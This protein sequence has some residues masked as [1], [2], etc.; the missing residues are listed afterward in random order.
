[1]YIRLDSTAHTRTRTKKTCHATKTRKTVWNWS[2]VTSQHPTQTLDVF[3]SPHT[4]SPSPPP[5]PCLRYRH[6]RAHTKIARAPPGPR[7]PLFVDAPPAAKSPMTYAAK[8]RVHHGITPTHLEQHHCYQHRPL[9]LMDAPPLLFAP[10]FH[11][12]IGFQ[13]IGQAAPQAFTCENDLKLPEPAPPS[14]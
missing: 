2:G 3:S 13:W 7:P 1:M 4:P 12:V 6:T 11:S 8:S 10:S 5:P 9:P 14:F